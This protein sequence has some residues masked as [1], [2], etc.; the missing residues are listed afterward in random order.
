MKAIDNFR[1][2][3]VSLENGKKFLNEQEYENFVNF[4]TEMREDLLRNLLE[5]PIDEFTEINEL[6][7]RWKW[8]ELFNMLYGKDEICLLEVASGDADMIPQSLSVSNPNSKYIT[9]N[10]NKA[11]NESL[12]RKTKDLNI[13]LELIDDDAGMITE[14]IKER[15]VDIIVFQH[16]V[17]DVLQGIL[18]A[19]NDVDTVNCDWMECLPKMIELVKNEVSNNSF[20]ESLKEPFLNLL[21]TLASVLKTEG[22]IA[23]SH[24]MF[25]LDLDLG[26]P[27]EIFEDLILIVRKWL[28]DNDEFEEV[29]YD[30]FDNQ[31]WIFLKK[32]MN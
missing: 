4:N 17:N 11:L 21:K 3:I 31:W 26:Y 20:D 27:R 1:S 14:Y 2:E 7:F 22:L 12:I 13:N 18:C 9:A 32:K 15:E 16:G 30:G 29:F 25:Q 28:V 6:Y 23:I 5:K 10:M 8:S 19:K 24:Y